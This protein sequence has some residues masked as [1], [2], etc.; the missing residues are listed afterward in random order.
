MHQNNPSGL[1]YGFS[2]SE[3][4]RVY[5]LSI[6]T[7]VLMILMVCVCAVFWDCSRPRAVTVF[8]KPHITWPASSTGSL[9]LKQ[10]L[11]SSLARLTEVWDVFTVIGKPCFALYQRLIHSANP[12]S[13]RWV[14]AR[15]SY[16]SHV[17]LSCWLTVKWAP[18]A[19]GHVHYQFRKMWF[20]GGGGQERQQATLWYYGMRTTLLLSE[21]EY[22]Q[23][24]HLCLYELSILLQLLR[25][26]IKQRKWIKNQNKKKKGGR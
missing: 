16:L 23:F 1:F 8:Q 13:C 18:V 5:L 14:T 11:N 24:L 21:L 26:R 9:S 12:S 7:C 10:L 25:S 20:G 22:I 17:S 4:M 19:A 3:S 2:L 6:Y 15:W